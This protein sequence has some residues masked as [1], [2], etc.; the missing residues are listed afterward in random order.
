MVNEVRA[1]FELCRMIPIRLIFLAS[2]RSASPPV[3]YAMLTRNFLRLDRR[4]PISQVLVF[5]AS[6]SLPIRTN[7]LDIC[8]RR[9]TLYPAELRVRGGLHSRN[10]GCAAM[11]EIVVSGGPGR[12]VGPAYAPKSRIAQPVI[13]SPLRNCSTS[14]S[15]GSLP[16]P[17]TAVATITSHLRENATARTLSLSPPVTR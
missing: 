5:L 8:L 15:G 7:W 1:G 16:D 10:A 13:T 11:R 3:A 2:L 4:S 14:S 6:F 12:I 9:A 17:V